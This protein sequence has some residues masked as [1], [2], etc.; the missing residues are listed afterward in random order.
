M[1]MRRGGLTGVMGAAKNTT[2]FLLSAHSYDVGMG[3]HSCA[4]CVLANPWDL[5]IAAQHNPELFEQYLQVERDVKASFKADISLGNIAE[6]L[7][8]AQTQDLSQGLK[9]L[10]LAR[11]YL[12]SM[13]SQWRTWN[14]ERKQKAAPPPPPPP[15]ELPLFGKGVFWTLKKAAFHPYHGKGKRTGAPGHYDYEYEEEWSAKKEL[16]ETEGISAGVGGLFDQALDALKERHLTAKR[17]LASTRKKEKRPALQA[18][19]DR[20]AAKIQR[21]TGQKKKRAKFTPRGM[22]EEIHF[23]GAAAGTQDDWPQDEHPLTPAFWAGIDVLNRHLVKPSTMRR[24]PL[25]VA[26]AVAKEAK[27]GALT[28][29]EKRKEAV[30]QHDR[31]RAVRLESLAAQLDEFAKLGKYATGR[32]SLRQQKRVEGQPGLFDP[33]AAPLKDDKNSGQMSLFASMRLVDLCRF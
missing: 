5:A 26:N 31:A 13:R 10:G 22:V 16:H 21:A 25:A 32:V 14:K 23:A 4:F 9:D 8:Q 19:V 6:F 28:L 24:T 33:P 7:A 15:K 11:E 17:R 20:L 12:A 1:M 30:S 3:R 18:E 2:H 29:R 27:E